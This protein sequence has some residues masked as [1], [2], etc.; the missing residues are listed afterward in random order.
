[1]ICAVKVLHGEPA[2]TIACAAFGTTGLLT[3]K[4][5]LDLGVSTENLSAAARKGV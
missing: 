5:V 2:A 3:F 1:M 4:T